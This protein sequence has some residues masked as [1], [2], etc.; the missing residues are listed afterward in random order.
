MKKTFLSFFLLIAF[1]LSLAAKEAAEP[2]MAKK[3]P[4]EMTIHNDTRVDNYFWLRERENPDVKAYLAAENAYADT[5]MKP[6]SDFQEKLYKEMLSHIKETDLSVPF[7]Y[8]DY[9]YYSRT[10]E[11]KQYSIHCRKKGSL[12][13]PEEVLLDENKL[14]EGQ[15]FMSLGALEVSPDGNLLAYSTDN[16]GFRDFTLQIMDLRSSEMFPLKVERVSSVVW[17]LDNKTLFYTTTDP[18]KR[19][20]RLYRHVLGTDKHELVEEEKDELYRLFARA[21]RNEEIIFI[22][23]VSSNTTEYKYLYSSKPAEKPILILPRETE[24]EY[25]PD[26]YKGKFFIL[27]NKDAKNYRVVSAPMENP[28]IEN[29]KDF[30]PHQK[31][32]LLEGVDFFANHCVVSY[33]E[34]AIPTLRVIDLRTGDSNK[35]DVPEPIYSAYVSANTVFDTN[36]VRFS[37]QSFVTPNS[38]FDYDMDTR[39]KTLLK[40]RE[41][42]GGFDSVNYVSERTH[43]TAKDGVKIPVSIVY[44]KGVKKDGTAPLLLRGYGAYGSST[45]ANF[46]SDRLILLDRGMIVAYAHI[47][48]GGDLGKEWY[49]QGKMF[50]KKNT[51]TDFIAVAEHLIAQKYTSAD[52]LAATGG[53]AGGLLMGAVMNQRPDLFKV[54]LNYV[55]YVDVIN[56]MLD[57]TIPLVVPEY[58][59]WGNPNKKDEYVYMKSYCPYTNVKAQKYPAM[60]VRTSFYD[61]QVPYWEGAKY[62]AKLRALKTDQNVILLKS[63]IEAGGHGGQSGRYDSL[64][65]D[66]FDYAFMLTQLGIKN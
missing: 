6:T 2:P 53:S 29:W 32:V 41:V 49:E 30:I 36:I 61:S 34:D 31:T 9:F 13:A 25:Y 4:K 55:P 20:Y 8:R 5:L 10:Q 16:T 45:S 57:P 48:G 35:I 38:V 50:H 26:Y 56:T 39:K 58:L 47:R 23:S 18:A 44:R 52:R 7:R 21:T 24:H 51:F 59:E 62:V 19:P 28:S 63:A 17:A 1:F 42:P 65:D 11:G 54:V 66:A 46:D 3:I 37:Y 43:A 33:R 27:T 22:G 14:A 40:Q 64:R 60:L 15:K 12:D